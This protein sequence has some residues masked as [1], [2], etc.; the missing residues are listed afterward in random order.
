MT[1]KTIKASDV[2][3]DNYY[4]YELTSSNYT[5]ALNGTIT[6]TC[7]VTDVY[8]DP[9][10]NKSITLYKNGT[11]VSTQTTNSS[12][13]ATWSVTCSTAGI[14]SFKVENKTIEVFVDNK[15]DT[16]HTHNQY[17][18]SSAITGMLTSSDI[19]DNLTTDSST[20][21]LSAKQGKT[22][23]DLIGQAISYINQ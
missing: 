20:K 18:T 16:G 3:G 5:P 14:Q 4:I 15:S 6:I 7:T 12:G 19:A 11:S 13:V 22:L 23:N 2:L 9:I 17:L 10:G 8:E 21:V 1:K